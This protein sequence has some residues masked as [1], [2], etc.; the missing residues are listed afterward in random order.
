MK[1]TAARTSA[2]VLVLSSLGA[3]HH[4]GSGASPTVGVS[5]SPDG[6][7]IAGV[8]AVV[9]TANASDANA[10]SLTLN[11]TFGDGQTAAGASVSH[12]YASEGVFA[13]SLQASDGRGG[14]TTAGTSITVAGLSGRWLLSEGG[15][16]F[17]EAGFDVTQ[18]G[19]TLAGWPF[20]V[21]DR[22]CLGPIA[23]RVLSPRSIR[24]EFRSC[25]GE[26]A[27]VDGSVAGDLRSASG[28]F[29]HP[30]VGT[31]PIVLTRQ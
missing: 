30:E 19:A 6:Q 15:Q 25:D 14:V 1:R 20:S 11:W 24:F 17:Y 18:A 31:Q 4:A 10:D 21:P 29:S 9:F 16:R 2:A 8:T 13:V 27:V 23:G 3:C 7:A 26:P 12:V 5:R 22:G 28:T